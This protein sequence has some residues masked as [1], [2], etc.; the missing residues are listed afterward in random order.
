LHEAALSS[1]LQVTNMS[2]SDI[3]TDVWQLSSVLKL[4]LNC[5]DLRDLPKQM[6]Q[7]TSLQV[8]VFLCGWSQAVSLTRSLALTLTLTLLPLPLS[9]SLSLSLSLFT[10]TY[11]PTRTLTRTCR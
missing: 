9:L 2:L 10:Y 4:N 5:N 6:S 7:M 11:T 8:C 1:N 3:P